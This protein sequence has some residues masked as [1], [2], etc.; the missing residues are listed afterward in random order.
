[1]DSVTLTASIDGKEVRNLTAQRAQ[2]PAFL[3]TYPSKNAVGVASGT[4]EANVSDGYWLMFPPLSA[5]LHTI[6]FT[7]DKTGGVF[8]GS[9]TKVT[10]HLI[11]SP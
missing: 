5:G 10:Y 6:S 4:Y 2:S 11:V 3:L 8:A 1:M 9:R 7:A